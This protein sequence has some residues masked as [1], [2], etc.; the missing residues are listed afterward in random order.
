MRQQGCKWF[1][2][3]G[4]LLAS[5]C[6]TVVSEKSRETARINY[7][8]GIASL[9]KGDSREA[10]RSLL[11]AVK[12]DPNLVEA[13]NALGLVFHAIGKQEQ[14]LLHYQKAIELNPKFSES[15]NNLGI[16]LLDMGRY[17]EAISA[18]NSA[19]A[20]VLYPTPYLA[21]GNMGWAYYKKGELAAALE[22]IGNAVAS[23]P[24]FC[25]GYEWLTK[26]ALEQHKPQD[27]VSNTQR[28]KK[29]CLDDPHIAAHLDPEYRREMAYYR[30]IGLLQLGHRDEARAVLLE[31][32]AVKS[33]TNNTGFA[34][35]C[36]Q[37]L[38]AL[39]P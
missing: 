35:K 10:L 38:K 11:I 18:F 3:Y 2:V 26:I 16:L 23:S 4:V 25:R 19:L 30:S 13:H 6:A 20:D 29:N 31:C 14:A 15:Y 1:L 37:S 22:H 17:D 5:A 24:Q 32:V 33:D 12:A 9:N 39:P 27:L 8:M 34:A 21:E 28:F 36:Q 7:D